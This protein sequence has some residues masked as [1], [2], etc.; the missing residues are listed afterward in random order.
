MRPKFPRRKLDRETKRMLIDIQA[1]M[2]TGAKDQ[3]N[4]PPPEESTGDEPI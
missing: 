3:N 4:E 1:L 2:L